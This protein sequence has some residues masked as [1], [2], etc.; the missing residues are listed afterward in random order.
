LGGWQFLGGLRAEI[1]IVGLRFL[2]PAV[3]LGSCMGGEVP[4]DML[5]WLRSCAVTREKISL[6]LRA[7]RLRISRSSKKRPERL[8]TPTTFSVMPKLA[9]IILC[10]SWGDSDLASVIFWFWPLKRSCSWLIW[11]MPDM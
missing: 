5:S 2:L 6:L 7:A 8:V 3:I 11:C 9:A 1:V 4:N 10:R